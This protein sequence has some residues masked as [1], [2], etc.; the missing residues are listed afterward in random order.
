LKAKFIGDPRSPGEA[1]NLPE[2][3]EAFGITFERGKWT[4][5]PDE[6]ASKFVGNTHYETKGD[7]DRKTDSER[8]VVV[9]EPQPEVKRPPL[10]PR[11]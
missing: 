1:K 11:A 9:T 6:L 10:T 3:T 4:D 5:V 2:T 7:D 8:K